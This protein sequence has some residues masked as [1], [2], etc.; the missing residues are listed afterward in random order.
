VFDAVAKAGEVDYKVI[1]SA[2]GLESS[3]GAMAVGLSGENVVSDESVLGS[4]VGSKSVTPI[5][6]GDKAAVNRVAENSDGDGDGDD[7]NDSGSKSVDSATDTYLKES[8]TDSWM[9]YSPHFCCKNL[10]KPHLRAFYPFIEK[11]RYPSKLDVPPPSFC[12]GG[13]GSRPI[14]LSIIRRWLAVCRARHGEHCEGSAETSSTPKPERG[15]PRRL[16]DVERW[17]VV[18]AERHAY[19]TLSYVW[20]RQAVSESVQLTDDR[21]D[22]LAAPYGLKRLR[23]PKTI[24][25]AMELVRRL[26]EKYLWV[27]RLCI[28]QS[29]NLGGIQDEMAEMAEIYA[30][31]VLTIV[32]GQGKD[33]MDPL[34][35]GGIV[36]TPEVEIWD[37]SAERKSRQDIMHSLARSLVM[38]TWFSRGWTFQEYHFSRR[39]LI[40][41]GDTIVWEC[42][43]ASWHEGHQVENE[44]EQQPC[45]K[46][47]PGQT[48]FDLDPWPNF[49]RFARLLCLFNIR[50][51]TYPEDAL[52]ALNGALSALSAVFEGG[53]VSGLPQTIFDAALLWQPYYPMERRKQKQTRAGASLE[54]ILPTWSPLGWW[55]SIYSEDWVAGCNP[56]KDCNSDLFLQSAY[57]IS[58]VRWEYK[59]LD[60]HRENWSRIN[61]ST[62]RRSSP[63]VQPEHLPPKWSFDTASGTFR[64]ADLPTK[65]FWYPVPIL[66]SGSSPPRPRPVLTPHIRGE[67][68]TAYL[69]TVP[70]GTARKGNCAHAVIRNG[71]ESIGYIRLNEAG[72]STEERRCLLIEL[73]RGETRRGHDNFVDHYVE[74]E[75]DL[76]TE[77]GLEEDKPYLFVNVMWVSLDN[78]IAERIAVGRVKVE[79]WEAVAGPTVMITLG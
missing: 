58:T 32:A 17:C 41:C 29:G 24:V 59:L 53:F 27:D 67:T 31:A 13:R 68:R 46:Q 43:C 38:S 3:R 20:G 47:P 8:P 69:S 76:A 49:H 60:G 48:G 56:L 35:P 30:G 73:S 21:A 42:H 57:T 64:H 63:G 5:I 10:V 61:V 33:A 16:I 25:Q 62:G 37:P 12:Q 52:H 79:A 40:F 66:A 71:G 23:L 4:S 78:G 45:G 15:R 65:E 19:V 54:A 36:D 6:G 7:D 50:H 74:F 70:R 28:N 14:A 72:S 55:G 39:K 77:L 22:E 26:G 44:D 2:R 11:V 9:H 34:W 75:P 18:T 51:L 1:G